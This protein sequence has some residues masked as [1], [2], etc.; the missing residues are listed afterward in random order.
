MDEQALPAGP[1]KIVFAELALGAYSIWS[2]TLAWNGSNPGIFIFASIFGIGL[3]TV[4]FTSILHNVRLRV[5]RNRRE[6]TVRA[7][8]ES[9]EALPLL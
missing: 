6:R 8:Q 2:A 4:A 1:D 3:L 7:E 5:A 9:I